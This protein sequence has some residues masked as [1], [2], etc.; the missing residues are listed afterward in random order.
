MFTKEQKEFL[1]QLQLKGVQ[2]AVAD[3]PLGWCSTNAEGIEQY[4]TSPTQFW[5]DSYEVTFS[6]ITE[7]LD[8][9]NNPYCRAITKRGSTCGRHLW[10]LPLSPGSYNPATHNYCATHRKIKEVAQ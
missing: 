7:F 6:K 2:M 1:T 9:Q 4:C 3:G 8:I 10:D 5:A